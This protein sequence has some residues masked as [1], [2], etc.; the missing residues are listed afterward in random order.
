MV[1]VKADMEIG[2]ILLVFQLDPAAGYFDELK[3]LVTEKASAID[4]VESVEVEVSSKVVSHAVQQN[5][6]PQEG[7]R[8]SPARAEN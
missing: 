3:K 6:K 4:G 7:I 1:I 5:L 8:A 2:E